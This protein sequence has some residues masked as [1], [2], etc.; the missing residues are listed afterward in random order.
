[1]KLMKICI[2]FGSTLYC[3]QQIEIQCAESSIWKIC[4]RSLRLVNVKNEES[5][6]IYVAFAMIGQISVHSGN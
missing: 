6:L 2:N 3:N 5:N 1:M 4:T